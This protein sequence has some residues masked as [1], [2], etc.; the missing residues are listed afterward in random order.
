VISP[1]NA[2][3]ASYALALLVAAGLAVV[4]RRGHTWRL[5]SSKVSAGLM[6]QWAPFI[7]GSLTF[8]AVAAAWGS[9][10]E[11]GVMH[12]ERAYLLQA[13]IF[14]SG[15]WTAPRPP[16]A[17]FFEQMHV[18]IEPAVF[19]KYPPAHALTLVPGIWLNLPGLMPAVM[20]GVS[21]ALVFWI[22]RRAANQWVALFTW[23]LW[24]TAWPTLMWGASYFSETTSTTTLLIASWAAIRW[25]DSTQARY[26]FVVAATLA[27]GLEARPLT[28]LAVG[29][30]LGAII[31]CRAIRIDSQRELFGPLALGMAILMLEPVWHQRTLGSWRLDPY[32]EYS[33]EYFP[34]DKPGFGVEPTPAVRPLTPE[35]AYV[36]R[37]SRDIHAQHRLTSLP[38]TLGARLLGL[39]YWCSEGWRLAIGVLMCAGM[40]R[41]RG[42]ERVGL[43]AAGCLLLSYLIFAHPPMWIVY[44][45]EILPVL[46]FFGARELVRVSSP[47]AGDLHASMSSASLAAMLIF[48][49]LGVADVVRVRTAIEQRN[50][51]N[52]KGTAAIASVPAGKAI[53]FVRFPPAQSHHLALTSNDPDLD[54][55]ERWVVYD[56]GAMNERLRLL[57]PERTAYLLDAATFQIE[58]MPPIDR[59]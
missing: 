48:I 35:L 21:G 30:P 51:F 13:R 10:H 41:V 52:Q 15:R 16:L 59:H 11:P 32:S 50:E 38:L 9:F 37:W 19:A 46:Y 54:R 42:A 56:R 36:G 5:H 1:P 3:A 20:M 45:V 12:D 8:L 29:T 34:F 47:A 28:V 57:A 33:A 43:L 53:V 2:T 31:L 6:G 18:F 14:A 44:Y 49:P 55:A 7:A 40:A 4:S 24:T 27:W 22:A 58:Q 25:I 39:L 23:W 26:L 17:T